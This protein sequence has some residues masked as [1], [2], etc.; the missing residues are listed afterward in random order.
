MSK[1][2]RDWLSRPS[3]AAWQI[4]IFPGI[5]VLM[6]IILASMGR[7]G[8]C[9]SG[10]WWPWSWD[11]WSRHNSQHFVDP[12]TLSHFEHG[13]GLYLV[14]VLQISQRWTNY[15]RACT[16]AIVEATW[17]VVENTDWM[18][19][20]YREVTVSLDYFGDSIWNSVGDLAACL[21]GVLI[22]SRLPLWIA[23]LLFAC[24]ELI[25]IVWIRDSLLLNILM[26]ISPVAAIRQWQ[27][28]GA[29]G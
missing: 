8:W 20:R 21:C 1:Q 14:L 29:T 10:D 19:A 7:V 12:Y 3:S 27:M 9:E 23:G 24:L 17:E 28:A 18:I 13:I 16:V 2:I 26:L 5:A 6:V 22:A 15:G 11:V 4:V 25:S